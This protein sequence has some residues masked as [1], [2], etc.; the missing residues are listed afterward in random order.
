[1]TAINQIERQDFWLE[2]CVAEPQLAS[3]SCQREETL[4]L[5]SMERSAPSLILP[6]R[7]IE[8]GVPHGTHPKCF[9][10]AGVFIRCPF[11]KKG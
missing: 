5:I 1:M 7:C 9:G 2:G 3:F 8:P 4:V 10:V 11:H 6:A